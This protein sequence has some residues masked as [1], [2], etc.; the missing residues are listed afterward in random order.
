MGSEVVS[1]CLLFETGIARTQNSSSGQC[2]VFP[3]ASARFEPGPHC[4]KFGA[5]AEEGLSGSAGLRVRGSEPTTYARERLCFSHEA[6]EWTPLRIRSI[7]RN[8]PSR[9]ELLLLPG[10]RPSLLLTN[11]TQFLQWENTVSLVLLHA[12]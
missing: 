4:T 6:D 7:L 1:T 10:L 5:E 12:V 11:D 2:A 9:E 3:C 8:R